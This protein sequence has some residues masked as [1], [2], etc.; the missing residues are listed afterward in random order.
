MKGIQNCSSQFDDDSEEDEEESDEDEGMGCC[1]LD[2][3]GGTSE[4]EDCLMTEVL[5]KSGTIFKPPVA[6]LKKNHFL[7]LIAEDMSNKYIRKCSALI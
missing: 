2:N 5:H 7:L 6:G 1:L 3:D 4:V